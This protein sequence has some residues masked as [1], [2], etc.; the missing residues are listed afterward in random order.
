MHANMIPLSLNRF[1]FYGFRTHK[2]SG[3]LDPIF[4]Q[5]LFI[6]VMVS[7]FVTSQ[8]DFT[9][10]QRIANGFSSIVGIDQ[11]TRWKYLSI[12][13]WK[14]SEFIIGWLLDCTGIVNLKLSIID[15][16]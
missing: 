15:S 3:L 5:R 11:K 9:T 16:C 1:P 4:A 10:T 8:G 2:G 14:A 7:A 13:L 12:I 6:L